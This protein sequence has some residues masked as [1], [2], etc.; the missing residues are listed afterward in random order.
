MRS[1]SC[2]SLRPTALAVFT[3][4]MG[5]AQAQTAA[6]AEADN[7]LET[8]LVTGIRAAKD[9]SLASKR[10]ADGVTEVISAEDIGKMPDKNVA[11]ALQRL[12]GINTATGTGGNGGYDENDRVSMRG[13]SPSLSLV[14]L[15]GH[16]VASAD[17]DYG[18]MIAGGAGPNTSGSARSVSFLLLPSEL[19]SQV[20]VHKSAQADDIEGGVAGS[21]DIITRRPLD[22][23][24][25]F[26]AEIGLQAVYS[27]RAGKTDPQLSALVNWK[28]AGSTF[29]VMGQFFDERRHVRRDGQTRNYGVATAAQANAAVPVGTTF[30]S[31]VATQL[32]EQER[33]RRGG[34]LGVQWK[35]SDAL[36]LGAEAFMSQLDASYYRQVFSTDFANSLNSKVVPTG[37]VI[38]NGVLTGGTFA[39]TTNNGS[40]LQAT[41]NPGAAVKTNYYTADFKLKASEQ[42]SV[43][44]LVGTTKAEGKAD[45]YEHYM[46][47]RGV[48]QAYALGNESGAMNISLPNGLS[49][50]NWNFIRSDHNHTLASSV[51][52]EDFA[53]LDGEWSF[54]S[55][56]L[57]S[58]KFGWRGADHLRQAY[59][60]LKTGWPMNAAGTGQVD[61]GLPQ[62]AWDGKTLPSDVGA[63]LGDGAGGLAGYVPSLSPST[64]Q[65]WS[66]ANLSND[67][68]FNRPASGPFRVGE[69]SQALYVM[70]KLSGDA[71]RGNVGLRYVKTD[72]SVTTNTGV[73]C[74]AAGSRA[75]N[76][77]LITYGSALQASECAAFVPTGATLTTGSR[78]GNFFTMTT[79]SK[80]SELLPSASLVFDLSKNLT[81]RAAVA[82]TMSRPEYSALGTAIGNFQYN[83]ASTPVSTA[84]GGNPKLEPV[85]AKN[86]NLGVEWYFQPR[87]LLSAQV[88]VIDFDSLIGAGSSVQYLF[89]TAAKDPVTGVLKPAF[90]DTTVSQ[91]ISVTGKSKGVELGW[92]QPLWG[93]F[94]AN[95]NYTF[96]DAKEANGNPI[97]GA[98][99]HTYNLGAYYEDE[100]FNARIA[101]AHRS[102]IR[103]GLYGAQQSYAAASG[104][105][106]ASFG[107]KLTD[108]L[109]LSVEGLN[110]NSPTL[111]YFNKVPTNAALPEQTTALYNS[112]RQVYVGLRYKY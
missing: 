111:R 57:N 61:S 11:D 94:G 71:W 59:R 87:S 91:P 17:W 67:P 38:S 96:A 53:Q 62:I 65:Q 27:D 29:G 64:I 82:K 110:L 14:T 108:A 51:D 98:A 45:F 22:F 41:Y 100:R 81:V 79:D 101:Y 42:L 21:I 103:I 30:V 104:T 4:L 88:F 16:S 72:T 7:K 18:D 2:L 3:L 47:F 70:A 69:K 10:Y 12:P 58:L 35:A 93:G 85:V 75:A 92:E 25:P 68:V 32:F 112:G 83:P 80:G 44:G 60:P 56:A 24:K 77:T 33:K 54:D 46:S 36:T 15:N 84:A 31:N 19:V 74:G 106:N 95:A 40:N 9:K 55:G 105:V 8:V 89:N 6:P 50:S 109:T 48:S 34:V 28:N 26:T 76:G 5:A 1:T 52:R 99:R 23:K 107:V 13:T 78:F 73:S 63:S 49:V 20:V 86:Y 43:N 39:N 37:A 90:M 97:M 66:E 102:E